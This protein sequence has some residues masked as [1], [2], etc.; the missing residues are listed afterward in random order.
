MLNNEYISSFELNLLSENLMVS[1]IILSVNPISFKTY[2]GSVLEHALPVDAAN[3][4]AAL[5]RSS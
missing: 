5:F 2:E 3:I 1:C 4:F